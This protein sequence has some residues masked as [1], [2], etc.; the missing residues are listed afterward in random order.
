MN[1]RHG[2][3]YRFVVVPRILHFADHRQ[4]RTGTRTGNKDRTRS[5]HSNDES[6]ICNDVVPEIEV[7]GLR[8]GSGA[9]GC[10]DANDNDEDCNVDRYEARPSPSYSLKTAFRNHHT[11]KPIKGRAETEQHKKI[12]LTTTQSSQ[13]SSHSH[14][15]Q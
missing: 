6:G 4:K 15:P 12:K 2:N 14:T 3:I 7:A 13:T 9:V 5:R 1:N 11:P 8:C 10:G